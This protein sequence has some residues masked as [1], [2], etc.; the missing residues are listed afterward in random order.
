MKVK[1]LRW[2]IIG[3]IFVATVINYIDRSALA[4]MWGGIDKEGTIA[5]S[6]QLT[7]EDYENLNV[8]KSIDGGISWKEISK[9]VNGPVDF[10]A[11]GI[12]TANP[13]ILYGWFSG[14]QKSEDGGYTWKKIETTQIDA[15]FDAL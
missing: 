11:M 4:I 15:V 12:S 2:V 8:I 6:L 3:L 1:G 7:K 5:H 13:D 10:H 9:G 14:L